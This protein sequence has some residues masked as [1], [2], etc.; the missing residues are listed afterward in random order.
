MRGELKVEC[1]STSAD[2]VIELIFTM[3]VYLY[4]LIQSTNLLTRVEGDLKLSCYNRVI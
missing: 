4:R 2:E 1:C 3:K